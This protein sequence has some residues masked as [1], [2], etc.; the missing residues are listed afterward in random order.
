MT[1]TSESVEQRICERAHSPWQ[2]AA[3]PVLEGR[4]QVTYNETTGE[5]TGCSVDPLIGTA[6]F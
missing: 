5:E 4:Q 3:S 2:Q 6:I 1:A